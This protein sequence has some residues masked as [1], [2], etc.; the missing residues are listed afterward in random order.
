MG[1]ARLKANPEWL[2]YRTVKVDKKTPHDY[3]SLNPFHLTEQTAVVDKRERLAGVKMFLHNGTSVCGS[4]KVV[5]LPRLL[6]IVK[7]H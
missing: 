7:L 1:G 3:H 6:H 5:L 2:T 4:Y